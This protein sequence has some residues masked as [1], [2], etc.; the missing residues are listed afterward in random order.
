[1]SDFLAA[2]PDYAATA[3]LDELRASE[4]SYLDSG[5]HVYLDYTGAGLASDAQLR[6]HVERVRGG[7]FGNPHS[8][9]PASAASTVLIEQARQAV[10]RYFNAAAEEY[11]VIFTQN[12][13]GACRLVGEAYPFGPRSR[14]VLTADNHNAMNG[15]REFA[16]AGGAAVRYAGVSPR[17]TSPRRSGAPNVPGTAAGG[18]CSATRRRAT[19]AASS[20][21]WPGWT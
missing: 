5:G 20:T 1:V 13:T 19:S 17:P 18:A 8:E 6:A 16:R 2:Y 4:Y 15:I 10:L 11:A 3:R 21:R 14:L 12:A 7:C 9:S